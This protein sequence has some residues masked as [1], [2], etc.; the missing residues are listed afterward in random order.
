MSIPAPPPKPETA[1]PGDQDS[2]QH[3]SLFKTLRNRMVQGLFVAL[4]LLVTFFVLKWLYDMLYGY[5]IRP[6]SS[7]LYT[8]WL[9]SDLAENGKQQFLGK[10]LQYWMENIFAPIAA[11]L[12]VFGLLF[13]SGMFFRSRLH[14]FSDWVLTNVPGVGTIY[15]SV[16][17]VI[18]AI[19]RSQQETGKFQRTVLVHFPHVGMK[20]P[21]FVTSSCVDADTREK[22]LCVYVPTTPIPTSGYM[23]LVP[24]SEVIDLDWTLQETLQAIVSGGITV[25]SSVRY[26]DLPGKI[27]DKK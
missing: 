23:L 15:S 24:E 4:P 2:H 12:V 16:K 27:E 10:D 14:R 21:A 3:L 20:V 1:E 9:S 13:L 7:V 26:G 25:P 11:L 5:I 19:H 18:D 8:Y 6:I 22:I 17:N